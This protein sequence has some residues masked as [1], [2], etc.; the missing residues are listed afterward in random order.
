MLTWGQRTLLMGILNITPDSFSDGGTFV[1]SDTQTAA[2]G[3]DTKN[4]AAVVEAAQQMVKDGA[5]LLD[6]GGQSTR[7]GAT[8]LTAAQEAARVVPVIR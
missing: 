1:G 3:S 8:L 7:P 2:P 5:D 4:L 6:V